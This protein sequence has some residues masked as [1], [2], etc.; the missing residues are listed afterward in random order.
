MKSRYLF[1]LA[2]LLCTC[3]SSWNV[4]AKV[5]ETSQI[6]DV[7]PYLEDNATWVLVDLD[8][9]FFEGAQAYGHTQ[10]FYDEVEIRKEQGLTREEAIA[11][12]Y[13]IWIESQKINKVQPL[14][15]N[16]IAILSTKQASG[17]PIMGLTQRQPSI[18][19]DTVRQV[20]SLG[21]DFLTTAPFQQNFIMQGKGGPARYLQ[22]ILFV[23]DYNTKID[24]FL[25]FLNKIGKAP[26]KVVFIDDKRKNVDELEGLANYGIEYTGVHYTAIDHAKPVY[27]RKIAQFQRKFLNQILSN[28][29]ALLLMQRLE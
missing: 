27:D 19:E 16:F 22:G 1:A 20:W 4:E 5:I 10:W 14:D 3:F 18:A 8:L 15:P 25:S 23:S 11:D 17:M 24:V 21:F 13:P 26:K 28:E 12:F 2:T 6:Q 29:G 7:V 9:C